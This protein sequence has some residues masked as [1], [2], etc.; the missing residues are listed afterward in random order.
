ME[1]DI[2]EL[3]KHLNDGHLKIIYKLI[4]DL[5]FIK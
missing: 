5:T 3:L 1:K 4:K 2:I